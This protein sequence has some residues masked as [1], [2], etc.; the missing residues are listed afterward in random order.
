MSVTLGG[1]YGLS[2]VEAII[3]LQGPADPN[4]FQVVVRVLI[5]ISL[6]VRG[7]Q[8]MSSIKPIEV[9]HSAGGGTLDN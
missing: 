3:G 1:D 5:C 7:E 9:S 6:G 2:G 8:A 4:E